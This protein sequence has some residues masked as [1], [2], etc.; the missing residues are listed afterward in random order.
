MDETLLEEMQK[1]ADSLRRQASDQ[2]YDADLIE[3]EAATKRNYAGK[4]RA[5]ADEIEAAI[6]KL[7]ASP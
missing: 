6:A 3:R 7:K 4:M 2:E 5:R 1:R